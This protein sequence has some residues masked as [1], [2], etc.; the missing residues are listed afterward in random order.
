VL[1]FAYGVVRHRELDA[2]LR[3]RREPR[4]YDAAL[5]L[6]APIGVAAGI[7]SLLLVLFAP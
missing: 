7:A 3:E 1:A 4:R 6:L 2:A 5:L